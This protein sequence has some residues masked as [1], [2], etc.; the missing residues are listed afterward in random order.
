MAC[1]CPHAM[2]QFAVIAEKRAEFGLADA[3]CVFQHRIEHR[4]KF[5]GRTGNDAETSEVAV[6]CSSASLRS[7]VRWRSSLSSRVFSMAMTAW[8]AKFYTS[9]ICL[10]VNG[11][12]S[13]RH[14]TMAP[15]AIH[16]PAA[17]ER[18]T[19]DPGLRAR[20]LGIGKFRDDGGCTGSSRWMI[21]LSMIDATGQSSPGV[22]ALRP[23]PSVTASAVTGNM[24]R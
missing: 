14:M 18:P 12:T 4:L 24:P 3:C 5:A 7:S 15:S 22:A 20:R 2:Q 1:R 23:G 6:C 16:S 21:A 17:T 10:S 9:A 8:A 19:S 13:W 11:F